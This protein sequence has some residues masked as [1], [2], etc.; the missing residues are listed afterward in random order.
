VCVSVRNDWVEKRISKPRI[1]KDKGKAAIFAGPGLK[2]LQISVYTL[3]GV[4]ILSGSVDSRSISNKSK[5]L[6][7]VVTGVNGLENR[8]AIKSGK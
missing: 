3:K 5:Y 8:L 2:T 7:S 6:A 1:G 4:M